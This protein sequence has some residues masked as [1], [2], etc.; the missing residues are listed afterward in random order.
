MSVPEADRLRH[1]DLC[2][3]IKHCNLEYYYYDRS[4]ISD[5]QYD[6]LFQ[7]LKALEQQYPAL[8]TKDSPTQTVGHTPYNTFERVKHPYPML[9]LGNVFSAEELYAWVQSLP[10][11]TILIGELKLDGVSLSLH[12]EGGLLVRAV[13]RGDG[14]V[15][16]DV[17]LN[18]LQIQGIPRQLKHR[19]VSDPVSEVVRG[20]VVVSKVD[21]TEYNQTLV[22]QGKE[23]YVNERNYASGSLRQKD[24]RVTAERR[25]RFY[26][27]SYSR[28]GTTLASHTTGQ[29]LL[30]L[31]GFT[32]VLQLGSIK[33]QTDLGYWQSL[34]D[35]WARMRSDIIN[36]I[37]GLVFK[38]DDTQ[39]QQLLGYRSREPRWA[40]AYKF[41][42][43]EAATQFLGIQWQVGR[44][45][46]VTPVAKLKPVFVGGV[47]V[48]SA[49]LHNPAEIQRLNLHIGDTVVV[50]RA[51]DVIPKIERVLV[52]LRPEGAV[53]V[54]PPTECP[55]CG[56]RLEHS[57]VEA[58]CRNLQCPDQVGRAL[59]HAVSRDVLNIRDL[60]PET[61]TALQEL[62]LV[63]D[64]V[65]LMHL[66]VEQM[67]K[68]QDLSPKVAAKI[69]QEIK[70][71]RTQ[72][73]YRV[74]LALGIPEVGE[75]TA[76]TLERYF[77][78]FDALLQTTHE[79]LLRLPDIG[80]KT[81][82]EIMS[83]LQN[84]TELL[85]RVKGTFEILPGKRPEHQP[86]LGQTYVVTGS[87]FGDKTRKEIEAELRDKGAS[88]SSGVT[89]NTTMV[90]AGTKATRH[91]VDTAKHLGIPVREFFTHD[92][93]L[94]TL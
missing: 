52:E 36:M 24:P 6:S 46:V 42:A 11:G 19:Q 69:V 93:T 64:L 61:L 49:T 45:G 68:L 48:S 72:P 57:E 5:A 13:T 78:N 1:A 38:V 33:T 12:Y 34:V 76:R 8:V 9:S 88:L 60:G 85:E 63:T 32:P 84:N 26:A 27:Y 31:A 77:P 70:L 73:F 92:I 39:Q 10:L 89:K 17:T 41:P 35:D 55:T 87:K 90:Y 62:H 30:E 14:Q 43:Q 29:H 40:V 7:E 91:K 21:F 47:T 58:W 28:N 50:K 74:L 2:R 25:L 56:S 51:G 37:D 94:T 23:P 83:F 15:G 20:E 18:A 80:P 75:S 65:S 67:T 53:L 66:N 4:V 54:E 71:A 16:E 81:A 3:C 86:L 59:V 44:T 82:Q 22:A 79:E